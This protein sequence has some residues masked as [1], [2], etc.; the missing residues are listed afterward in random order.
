[1]FLEFELLG[2]FCKNVFRMLDLMAHTFLNVGPTGT[3]LRRCFQD[4]GPTPTGSPTGN[5]AQ[6]A[7]KNGPV[8]VLAH[9]IQTQEICFYQDVPVISLGC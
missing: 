6:A 2:Q 9:P 3:L 4:F 7:L 8:E 5:V 1:M